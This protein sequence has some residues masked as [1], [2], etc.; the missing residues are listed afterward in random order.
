LKGKV[1][2]LT[3]ILV[4]LQEKIQ[5]QSRVMA[6]T[7]RFNLVSSLKFSG[8]AKEK[9][10]KLIELVIF[11]ITLIF[12]QKNLYEYL[13]GAGNDASFKRDTVYR[14]LNNPNSN[15]RYLVLKLAAAI[16]GFLKHLTNDERV[17]A[18]I[19]DDSAYYRDRS[20]KVE[21]LARV[22]DHT[23]NRYFKGFRK[24]TVGWTDGAT[25]IP[26]IFALLSSSKAKN[27]LYEQGPEVPIG[28]PGQL[29]R[30]EAIMKSTDVV[31]DMLSEILTYVKDFQYVLFDSWF[32]WPKVIK[33]VKAHHRDVI[34]MLKDMPTLFYTYKGKNYTLSNLYAQLNN[35]RFDKSSYIASI[36]VNYYGISARIVF[37]RNRNS[38]S[39]REWLALLST[40]IT[41]SEEEI[42]RIYGLRWDIE[43]YFK[44]CKSFLGLAKEFQGRSYDLMVSHTA[45][46]T[47]RYMLL[48]VE[49]RENQD[50]KAHG[51]IFYEFCDE[52]KSIEFREAFLL[53]VDLF[54]STLRENLFLSK[55]MINKIL[56]NFMS[57]LP[58]FMK[59][60]L[61]L[62]ST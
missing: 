20:E 37:V 57:K 34:C 41:I 6:F 61:G 19:V 48:S 24:L 25:F 4:D 55:Q 40:D 23:T 32:S 42:I 14:L 49:T 36:L 3:S 46:V 43:V 59:Y 11:V 62:A 30:Q 44:V 39:K 26:L 58:E 22:K 17:C 38:T 15:W 50:S 31:L 51:G 16:I 60:R 56:T 29:R 18:L 27:R 12:T 52:I 35:K 28:S 1:F 10:I 8:F 13:R 54:I 9:G 45:I 47:M 5:V 21:L 33:G 7:Q 2:R 53:I